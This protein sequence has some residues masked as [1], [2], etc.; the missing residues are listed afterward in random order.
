MHK[1]VCDAKQTKKQQHAIEAELDVLR[2]KVAQYEQEIASK[3][4]Y[5]S[6]MY[7]QIS[8]THKEILAGRRKNM[9]LSQRCSQMGVDLH[10]S[11][12]R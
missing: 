12:Y 5:V 6:R 2:Q 4:D 11:T 7:P 9:Q 1:L 8:K 3:K 10:G